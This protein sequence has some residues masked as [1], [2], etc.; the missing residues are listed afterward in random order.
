MNFDWDQTLASGNS[1][2]E[3]LHWLSIIAAI[4]AF[5]CGGLLVQE[6]LLMKS[7]QMFDGKVE[8]TSYE[9]RRRGPSFFNIDVATV[10][11]RLPMKYCWSVRTGDQVHH[12]D[13][14]LTLKVNDRF[15]G[16]IDWIKVVYLCCGPA[17]LFARFFEAEWA[18]HLSIRMF[19]NRIRAIP[20]GLLIIG[21]PALLLFFLVISPPFGLSSD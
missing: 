11:H 21:T 4:T 9:H 20:Y 13:G 14:A 15:V 19:E 18:G 8:K 3:Y 6:V 17:L 10:T 7:L 12:E 16:S 5:I 2:R 1:P